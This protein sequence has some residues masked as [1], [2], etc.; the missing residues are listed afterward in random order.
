MV[1][2]G[3]R[4]DMTQ[5]WSHELSKVLKGLTAVADYSTWC[6]PH[7]YGMCRCNLAGSY[8]SQGSKRHQRWHLQLVQDFAS[9]RLVKAGTASNIPNVEQSNPPPHQI[10]DPC[11]LGQSN[12]IFQHQ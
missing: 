7:S 12:R 11:V 6:F 4:N 3:C 5:Q 1:I 10:R 8:S 2:L 9:K